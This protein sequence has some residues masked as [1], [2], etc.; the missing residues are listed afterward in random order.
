[1]YNVCSQIF[2]AILLTMFTG[3]FSN[4]IWCYMYKKS[5]EKVSLLACSLLRLV[6]LFYI[7]PIGFI[8]INLVKRNGYLQGNHMWQLNFRVTNTM[9]TVILMFM[10]IW[11]GIAVFK[12]AGYHIVKQ[13]SLMGSIPE[14]DK[15]AI[16]EF[17]LAKKR[18]GI[19]KGVKIY[20]NDMIVSPKIQGII[21]G[22]IILPFRSF[23]KDQLKVIYS[24]EL[25]HYKHHDVFYKCCSALASGMLWF[26]GKVSFYR[27]KMLNELCEYDCDCATL[28]MLKGEINSKCYFNHILQCMYSDNN[29]E[30]FNEDNLE[31]KLFNNSTQ[32]KRRINYIELYENTKQISIHERKR[33]TKVFIVV[34]IVMALIS[35]YGMS[36]L[37][38]FIYKKTENVKIIDV[39]KRPN[40]KIVIEKMINKNYEN[41]SQKNDNF[42]LLGAE[43]V[44]V[45]D[46]WYI[47]PGDCYQ[48]DSL[49]VQKGQQIAV[50]SIVIPST[51]VCWVGI[52]QKSSG[53][54]AYEESMEFFDC[55]FNVPEDGE[56]QVFVQNKGTKEI[57]VNLQITLN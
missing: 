40:E 25:M 5:K 27:N 23:T 29:R 1:M 13:Q 28:E 8:L 18:M 35:G 11:M 33:I 4:I 26:L 17:N 51:E 30:E 34:N 20:R 3:L 21:F 52:I 37:N 50:G 22:R 15:E 55:K 45:N 9:G 7:L 36:I 14:E 32:L 39:Q 46:T 24:H 19:N 41:F 31:I 47:M 10:V 44:T 53:E 43:C 12:I 16:T 54:A 6:C 57:T 49:K 56:Y 48:S 2:I 38:D 42:K